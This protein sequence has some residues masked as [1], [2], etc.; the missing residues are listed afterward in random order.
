MIVIAG[1]SPEHSY[2]TPDTQ[3]N[4]KEDDSVTVTFSK[5]WLYSIALPFC[6][7]LSQVFIDLAHGIMGDAGRAGLL[8]V[9]VLVRGSLAMLAI[10][11][12]LKF[13]ATLLKAFLLTFLLV[14]LFSNLVWATLSDIYKPLYEINQAMRLAFPWLMSGIFLYL[15]K[16][17]PID[18]LYLLKVLSW[19]G[20]LTAL[21]VIGSTV[22]DIGNKTYGE[23]S[24][25]SKG[26]FSA[27][28]DLG[29]TLI[30]T[31]VAS[32]VILAHTRKIFYL[33]VTAT[34]VSTCLLLGTR[35][36]V[37]GPV[38]VVIMFFMAALL[39]PN[40]FAAAG[41]RLSWRA[42][43]ILVLP[44]LVTLVVGGAIFSQSDK[45]NYLM[46]R[47]QSLT[48]HTPRS[49]LETAGIDRIEERKSILNLV[50]E[51]GM[52]FKKHVAENIGYERI[53]TDKSA[54]TLGDNQKQSYSV[55]RV[56]NDVLDIIGF[57]GM[58]QFF[59]IYA[60]LAL[61]YF[62]ALGKAIRD[63]NL[64]N[65]AILMI[66]TLFLAHSTLAGHGLFSAQV[67]T[68]LTPVLFLQLRDLQWG[69]DDHKTVVNIKTSS[70]ER[71]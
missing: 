23:W 55:H 27:Q 1:G 67:A 10:V 44:L 26:L 50:G 59:V 14:F 60:A 4:Q 2:S 37:L 36:G 54:I 22:L 66:F 46:K 33:V 45:T 30:L 8:S 43:T 51:G 24:Y 29:L 18:Q 53:R 13:R 19:A 15:N 35:T 41:E 47:I 48:E 57:Y 56:E 7:I 31:L 63:W 71:I 62:I 65:V 20:F 49:K 40:M 12:L 32:I 3:L 61:I 34:I 69:H 42:V 39:N 52:A 25:G 16:Q 9:G 5:S 6:L 70:T 21:T 28:N 38:I 68:V 11:V 58:I 64:E 17:A